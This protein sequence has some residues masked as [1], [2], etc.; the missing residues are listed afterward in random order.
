MSA[1]L[2]EKFAATG[3][4]ADYLAY[5]SEKEKENDDN[6]GNSPERTDSRRTGQVY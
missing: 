4:I 1:D 5:R 2:W 6:R 3:S